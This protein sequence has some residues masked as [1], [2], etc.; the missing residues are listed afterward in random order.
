[1]LLDNRFV[2]FYDLQ[3]GVWSQ[4]GLIRRPG[5]KA[6][7][8]V[9]CEKTKLVGVLSVRHKLSR[10]TFADGFKAAHQTRLFAL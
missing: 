8:Y 5:L 9:V 1:M 7:V 6:Q 4:L 10:L 3:S 2:S